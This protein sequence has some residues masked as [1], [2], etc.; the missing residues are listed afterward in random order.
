MSPMDD[1]QIMELVGQL[2]TAYQSGFAD[3]QVKL[4]E[5]ATKLDERHAVY[6]ER[7]G[8]MATDIDGAFKR[9]RAM[10]AGHARSALLNGLATGVITALL[11]AWA[12]KI[13]TG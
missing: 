10:E 1:M 4:Q 5:V 11:T 3:L 12:V 13:F 8:K 9:L 6:E 7:H 2:R